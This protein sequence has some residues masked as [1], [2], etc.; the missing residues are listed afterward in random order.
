MSLVTEQDSP[1]GGITL[2][3]DTEAGRA[4]INFVKFINLKIND[5]QIHHIPV[6][7]YKNGLF[8]VPHILEDI[9][10]GKNSGEKLVA[11]L[12]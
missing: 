5:R 10:Y 3:A 12:N 1:F 8:D 7:I 2:P 4:A 11:V 6:K 9:K